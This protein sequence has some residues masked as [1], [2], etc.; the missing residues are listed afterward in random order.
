MIYLLSTIWFQNRLVSYDNDGSF[1]S[2]L[3]INPLLKLSKD[4]SSSF[5]C[6]TRQ[7]KNIKG[8]ADTIWSLLQVN[9][10]LAVQKILN[11]ET[12]QHNR[13]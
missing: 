11:A 1:S 13:G 4:P 9:E 5:S 8:N 10:L 6:N 2:N 12:Y 3:A 7:Q